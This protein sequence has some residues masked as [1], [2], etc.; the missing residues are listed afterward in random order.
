LDSLGIFFDRNVGKTIPEALRDLGLTNVYHPHIDPKKC[1]EP[2]RE[3]IKGLFAHDE[4]DDVILRFCG[5]R[6]WI[7]CSQDHKYHLLENEREAI[8]QANVGV[9]YIWGANAKKWETFRVLAQVYDKLIEKAQ[10][11]PRPFIY[12]IASNGRFSVVAIDGKTRKKGT[13]QPSP[14]KSRSS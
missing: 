7:V 4:G 3:G 8:K 13:L 2:R 9:F 12:K 1:G 14:L 10:M 5:S 6:N 11:T